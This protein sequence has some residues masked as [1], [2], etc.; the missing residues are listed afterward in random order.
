[1][2]DPNSQAAREIG[3]RIARHRE[4]RGWSQTELSIQADIHG[5]MMSEI[6]AGKRMPSMP[7][8]IKIANAL[9]VSLAALQPAD[10]D[11]Y[12]RF[13]DDILLLMEKL[14]QL[15]NKQKKTMLA[16]FDAQLNILPKDFTL[17]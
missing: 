17:T 12:G 13:P 7:T 1:M 4:Q 14:N 5:S 16:M 6:E 15:P 9:H 11:Q 3:I 10:L 8:L 2:E